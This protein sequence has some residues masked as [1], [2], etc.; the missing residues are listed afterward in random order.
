MLFVLILCQ[1]FW[2]S[3]CM[4]PPSVEGANGSARDFTFLGFALGFCFGSA[5]LG[6]PGGIGGGAFF[7]FGGTY[8]VGAALN[9]GTPGGAALCGGASLGGAL[10]GGPSF[11]GGAFVG[12]A[13]CCGIA[14]G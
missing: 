10:V 8:E 14:L 7:G 4:N 13:P 5:G 1:C 3:G 11:G 6:Y 9:G 12:G 2:K